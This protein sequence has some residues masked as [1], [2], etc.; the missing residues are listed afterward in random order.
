MASNLM[1]GVVNGAYNLDL[2]FIIDAAVC[3]EKLSAKWPRKKPR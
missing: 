1:S 3:K 2:R